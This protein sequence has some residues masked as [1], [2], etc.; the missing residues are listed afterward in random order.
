MW[1]MKNQQQLIQRY[2]IWITISATLRAY[3]GKI[4]VVISMAKRVAAP[5]TRVSPYLDMRTGLLEHILLG[6]SG[7]AEDP[8]NTNG[9]NVRLS[10]RYNL[11]NAMVVVM[12]VLPFPGGQ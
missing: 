7:P 11:L 5:Y 10:R 3:F 2:D 1:R 8:R 12:C 9:A 4:V 6:Y